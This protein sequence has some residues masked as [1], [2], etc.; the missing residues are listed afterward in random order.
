[1]RAIFTICVPVAVPRLYH[2]ITLSPLTTIYSLLLML[3]TLALVRPQCNTNRTTL[4]L[5]VDSATWSVTNRSLSPF[6]CMGQ[7]QETSNEGRTQVSRN[8]IKEKQ[9]LLI[10]GSVAEARPMP[11][12]RPGGTTQDAYLPHNA[13]AYGHAKYVL[14]WYNSGAHSNY[15]LSG[16]I[17][18]ATA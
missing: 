5:L 15:G 6:H 7:D 10:E 14:R 4:M 13:V 8:K 16:D 11:V 1:M 12:E 17:T 18:R 9:Q 3:N 2:L